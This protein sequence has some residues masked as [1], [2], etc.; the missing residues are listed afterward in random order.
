MR[1]PSQPAADA[2]DDS[3]LNLWLLS[4]MCIF[5]SWTIEPGLLF[6]E[7]KQAVLLIQL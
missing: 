1:W 2:L 5:S 3:D 6:G 7:D 4:F